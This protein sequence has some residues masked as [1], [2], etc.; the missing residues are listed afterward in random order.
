MHRFCSALFCLVIHDIISNLENLDLNIWYLDD[1]TIAGKPDDFLTAFNTIIQKAQDLGLEVNFKKCEMSIIGTDV[2]DVKLDWHQ[3]FNIV[4]D[5]I[6]LMRTEHEFLLGSPLTSILC[7]NKKTVDLQ[8]L[9]ENLKSISMHSAYYLL[10]MSV[11]IPRLIFFLR[12]SPMWHNTAGLLRYDDVLRNSIESI[13]NISLTDRSWKESSLPIKYGGIG[14]RH[15][16]DIALPC[17][18]SSM[19][20]VS[21]LLDQLLPEP[22]RQIDPVLAEAEKQWCEKFGSLPEDNVRIYQHSWEIF[23]IEQKII[24]IQNSLYTKE[25]KARFLANSSVETGAWLQALPSPQLGT[26]LSNDEFR[27]ATSLRLGAAFVQPHKCK[28]G[29]K[30]NKFGRHGLSCAKASGTRPKHESANDIIQRALKSG[31]V[32]SIREPPGCSRSDGK[33]P[34]GLTLVPWAKGKSLL[35]DYTCADT[36]AKSYVNRTSHDKG[37]A[38]KQ[39]EDEKYKNYTD[40]MD[41]FIF[42]PIATE[43][44]GI[45]GKVGLQ[46]IKKIGSKITAVTHERRATS[47]LIQRIAVAIQRGNVASILGTLPETKNLGEIFYI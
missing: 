9:S 39:A 1:G 2:H 13:L 21:S 18:L 44:S 16:S 34:D 36:Y 22:L 17:F 35:W 26:H 45:F 37:Y 43:T 41:Q 24:S 30:V 38:A 27:I 5:G 15:A 10:R 28:C 14:I 40:L 29:S 19:Y 8:N 3:R 23:E 25:D 12:G 42:V 46:L 33:K 7:L 11:T 6:Q 32:P 4:S 20:N 47:Y 31:E